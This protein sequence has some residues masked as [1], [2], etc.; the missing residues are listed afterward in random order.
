V[1]DVALGKTKGGCGFMSRELIGTGST[2]HCYRETTENGSYIVKTLTETAQQGRFNAGFALQKRL[3]RG[4]AAPYIVKPLEARTED[5]VCRQVFEDDGGITLDQVEFANIREILQAVCG[6]AAALYQ[7]HKKKLV[8]VDVKA[9]NFLLCP[10][11][12]V[13]LFDFDSVLDLRKMAV[14]A[15]LHGPK[16]SRLAA[17]E[18]CG[19]AA[20]GT[21]EVEPA[22]TLENLPR[23]TPRLDVF[24]LG[25]L[26]YGLLLQKFPYLYA[27]TIPTLQK[28][29]RAL[30][31]NR[32]RGQMNGAQQKKLYQIMKRATEVDPARRYANAGALARNLQALLRNMDEASDGAE[33]GTAEDLLLTAAWV[34]N[35]HPLFRYESQAQAQPKKKQRQGVAEDAGFDV[36]LVGD[37][38]IRWEFLRLIFAC[39]QMPA[40]NGAAGY[41]PLKIQVLTEDPTRLYRELD[42]C[43]DWRKFLEIEDI[44][45][46]KADK[47]ARFFAKLVIK[48]KNINELAAAPYIVLLENDPE[49]N[50]KI[51]QL[52][53]EKLSNGQAKTGRAHRRAILVGDLRSDGA[54]PRKITLPAGLS[55]VDCRA[56]AMNGISVGDELKFRE[57]VK[58]DAFILHTYYTKQ[59]NQRASDRELQRAFENPDALYSSIR[60]VLTIP[61]K[62]AACGLGRASAPGETIC[63]WLAEYDKNP[64]GAHPQL[65]TMLHMEHR[66]WQ[67]FALTQGWKVPDEDLIQRQAFKPENPGHKLVNRAAEGNTG[68]YHP[69]LVDSQALSQELLP[70]SALN[71]EDWTGNSTLQLDPLDKLSLQLHNLCAKRVKRLNKTYP[72]LFDEL[73]N[74]IPDKNGAAYR[75]ACDLTAVGNKLLQGQSETD[76]LWKSIRADLALLLQDLPEAMAALQA[77]DYPMGLVLERNAFRD[78][79]RSDLDLIRAIPEILAPEEIACVYTLLSETDW[80]NVV[81]AVLAD[82]KE[83]VLLYDPALWTEKQAEERK[84]KYEKFFNNRFLTE[85]GEESAVKVTCLPLDTCRISARSVL[86]IT[87]AAPQTMHRVLQSKRLRKLPVVCYENGKLSGITKNGPCWSIYNG[88]G[89]SLN[90]AE[91]LELGGNTDLSARL[92]NEMLATHDFYKK[93]W[94]AAKDV[95]W[96]K[97]VRYIKDYISSE[98]GINISAGDG[99]KGSQW[100]ELNEVMLKSLGL[101]AVLDAL[102]DRGMLETWRIEDKKEEDGN[103]RKGFLTVTSKDPELQKLC[104][105]SISRL[106]TYVYLAPELPNRYELREVPNWRDPEKAAYVIRDR[107]LG[108][109][110][111][112]SAGNEQ[113]AVKAVVEALANA[114]LIQNLHE[115][116]KGRVST[117]DFMFAN[118]VV[119]ECLTKEGN[120]LEVF[121]YHAIVDSGIF[122]D[123]KIGTYIQWEAGD[124]QISR[125][126]TNEVDLICT[127]G[128]R[129]YFISC[130]RTYNL[131]QSY[132]DQVWY[133]AHRLGVDAVPIVLRSEK[134]NRSIETDKSRGERMGVKT[135]DIPSNLSAVQAAKELQKKLR[136][137]V[138]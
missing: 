33:T 128:V 115:G 17:P 40:K 114:Q 51:A 122:D 11:G 109:Q 96:N 20:D 52:L 22:V 25:A 119:R 37:N 80:C 26:L 123:V 108:F 89:R 5:S 131:D 100:T 3:Y 48:K 39:A 7:L 4:S 34:L 113:E 93:L 18:I 112:I 58:R 82:A 79:K 72:A 68:K 30:C 105:E 41:R 116:A 121:A 13:K 57:K 127:K 36:T 138:D 102:V 12:T 132:Y 43:G 19:T 98:Y 107:H 38:L 101:K 59:I 54:D 78:Y 65:Q 64:H 14:G 71:R 77:L 9:N 32:F 67:C 99:R 92:E 120:V 91:T 35:E 103:I 46:N 31:S 60:S 1:G 90:V 104:Q 118:E 75:R 49:E 86:D 2:C 56:F 106:Q 16:E 27:E 137:I 44:I 21:R 45:A 28:D 129:T 42:A 50:V 88:H 76:T 117:F 95:S 15:P 23:I 124:P 134:A 81:T 133:Q 125:Q 6:A 62:L 84:E 8:Y 47:K 10:D 74:C 97:G 69:C 85:P 73:K 66:S 126:T 110:C 135:V 87:G 63:R 61:Y 130:K 83:L 29:L 53:L 94:D 70:L 55:S 111:D 24:G 136:E